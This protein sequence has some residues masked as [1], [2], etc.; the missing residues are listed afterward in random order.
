MGA[1]HAIVLVLSTLGCDHWGQCSAQDA[2]VQGG[3]FSGCGSFGGLGCGG[4]GCGHGLGLCGLSGQSLPYGFLHCMNN[5]PQHFPYINP[6]WGYYF[7]RPYNYTVLIDQKIEIAAMGGNPKAP[8]DNRFLERIYEEVES[9]PS[10]SSTPPPYP[11]PPPS[12][13]ATAPL[14]PSDPLPPLPLPR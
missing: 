8:Y 9:M 6:A 14:A 3:L 12:V 7:Y 11:V 1:G 10:V 5:M 2:C 13:P 4:L